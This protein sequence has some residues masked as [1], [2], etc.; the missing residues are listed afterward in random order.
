[1]SQNHRI[2]RQSAMRGR[3]P[4]TVPKVSA[5][6]TVVKPSPHVAAINAK[7]RKSAKPSNKV[8]PGQAVAAGLVR[9]Q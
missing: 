6:P 7:L 4:V 9:P 3:K 8:T 2:P 5:T 1:M